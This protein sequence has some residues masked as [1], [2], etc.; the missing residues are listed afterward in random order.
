MFDVVPERDLSIPVRIVVIVIGQNN[1]G[2]DV[3]GHRREEA[4]LSVRS[5]R[6]GLENRGS[7]RLD[8]LVHL[9]ISL[10]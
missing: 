2:H 7:G 4:A 8:R 10:H 3:R 5:I 6:N 1:G 9:I